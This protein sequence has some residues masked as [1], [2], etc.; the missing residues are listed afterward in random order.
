MFTYLY[1]DIRDKETSNVLSC[2][3]TTN[4]FIEAGIDAGAVLIHCYGGV[5]R[6]AALVA[7]FLMS[8][9]GW[10][11]DQAMRELK[12]KRSVISINAGFEQQLKAYSRCN[13]NVYTAQQLLLRNRVKSLKD[14]RVLRGNNDSKEMIATTDRDT[15][16]P[17][18]NDDNEIEDDNISLTKKT[19]RYSRDDAEDINDDDSDLKDAAISLL[20]SQ[21][22]KKGINK[23]T[24]G[25]LVGGGSFRPKVPNIDP[26]TPLCR[27]SRP[28]NQSVR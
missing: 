26:K 3:P 28:G 15:V 13:Y 18:H 5:S 6:S 21:E 10:S 12:S 25:G 27:L 11:Y 4:I 1:I 2:I 17:K 16:I 14:Y 22:Y 24:G 19:K 9:Y 7:A 23:T 8:S 20:K